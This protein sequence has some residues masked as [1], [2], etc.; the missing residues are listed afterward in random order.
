MNKSIILV[1]ATLV[2]ASLFAEGNRITWKGGGDTPRW[3]DGS[4]W[5]GGEAPGEKDIAVI[6]EDTTAWA[7]HHTEANGGDLTLITSLA[8][9]DLVATNSVFEMD[10]QNDNELKTGTYTFSTPVMGVGVC[11]FSNGVNNDR[12]VSLKVDNSAFRGTFHFYH[13]QAWIDDLHALGTTNLVRWEP[14]AGLHCLYFHVEGTFENPVDVYTVPSIYPLIGANT[15]NSKTATGK[16]VILAGRVTNKTGGVFC[17]YGGNGYTTFTGGIDNGT[18]NKDSCRFQS[19]AHVAGDGILGDARVYT[20]Q[21]AYLG[22]LVTGTF[23]AA[24]GTVVCETN[25][26]LTGLIIYTPDPGSGTL[27]LNGYDQSP[28]K[29]NFQNMS[30]G[31]GSTT[32]ITSAAPAK[33][34]VSGLYSASTWYPFWGHIQGKV[35][36]EFTG[37]NNNATI[38]FAN[39]NNTKGEL[40]ITNKGTYEFLSTCSFTGV[41][42]IAILDGTS[43]YNTT[44]LLFHTA[45]INPGKFDLELNGAYAIADVDEGVQLDARTF[46]LDGKYLKAGVYGSADAQAA[47]TVDE[48]HVLANLTGLGTVKVRLD[49]P[50]GLM[51][52]LR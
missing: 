44:K 13:L 26:V 50:P 9:I 38:P 5:V 27:D 30:E 20:G 12:H 1:T 33:L 39:S 15:Y 16:P 49:G 22:A 25:N 52:L 29:F 19:A 42:R 3:S 24:G 14:G 23:M 43:K 32:V 11:K 51:L 31:N 10:S 40:T 41:K 2:C 34:S 4:N 47:G 21:T 35:S 28:L 48:D 36:L 45:N 37:A 18:N 6:P 7:S 46:K 8:A 17:P